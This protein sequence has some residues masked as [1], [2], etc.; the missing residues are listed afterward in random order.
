MTRKE[1]RSRVIIA[2][3][4][5]IA[6]LAAVASL[7]LAG[8]GAPAHAQGQNNAP[9]AKTN[10]TYGCPSGWSST[11]N[12]QTDV[13]MCFPTG[14]LS[15]K[16]YSKKEKETCAE[17][18]IEEQR[19]WCT[20]KGAKAASAAAASKAAKE[21]KDAKS[22]SN[23]DSSSSPSSAPSGPAADRLVSHATIAKADPL[24][25]CPLGYFSKSD[26]TICTTRLS[27]APRVRK[28][29][30]G[31][32]ADEIDEWGLYCTADAAV[33]TRAQAESEAVRDFNQIYSFN[34]GKVPA[35]GGDTDNYPSMV[36]AYGPKGGAQAAAAAP[37]AAGNGPAAQTAQCQTGDASAAG[38]AIGGAVG[39]QAG[40]AIGG[41]LGGLGKKKKK[42]SGC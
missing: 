10:K 9:V 4:L 1:N 41:M 3:G 19:V 2:G 13:S 17:G 8:L 6:N 11:K 30:G 21:A 7:A 35:Q 26:M 42:A 37:A 12:S 14:S 18:Y 39:G 31:C 25:R 28:N 22:A 5:S 33:I 34:R 24:D 27:P 38:A 32:N 16:I 29:S 23:A 15:P 20:T 36:A 40:A